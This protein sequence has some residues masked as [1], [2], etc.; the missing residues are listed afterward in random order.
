MRI[1]GEA[2]GGEPI[3]HFGVETMCQVGSPRHLG[4]VSKLRGF[5]LTGFK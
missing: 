4:S 3:L 1:G 2:P 5:I